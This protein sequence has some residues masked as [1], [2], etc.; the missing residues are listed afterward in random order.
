MLRACRVCSFADA[1]R[2]SVNVTVLNSIGVLSR[3]VGE[4][5]WARGRNGH[6]IEVRAVAGVVAWVVGQVDAVPAS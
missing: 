2:V 5:I 1:Q 4:P 3:V 6:M